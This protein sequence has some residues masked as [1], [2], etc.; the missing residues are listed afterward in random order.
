MGPHLADPIVVSLPFQKTREVK[1]KGIVGAKRIIST[2]LKESFMTREVNY[3]L[4]PAPLCKDLGK[5]RDNDN[6]QAP[7]K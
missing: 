4:R 6:K 3:Y 2:P 1:A 5:R 7:R